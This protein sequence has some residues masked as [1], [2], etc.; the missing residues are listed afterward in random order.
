LRVL[1]RRKGTME[2]DFL[3]NPTHRG[4]IRNTDQPEEKNNNELSKGARPHKR[5]I[6]S[7]VGGGN[8][9]NRREGGNG[10]GCET[11]GVTFIRSN[12]EGDGKISN[13]KKEDQRSRRRNTT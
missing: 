13:L 1:A 6:T 9:R 3:R 8:R 10:S 5:K 4:L 11:N 7:G 12:K 2:N